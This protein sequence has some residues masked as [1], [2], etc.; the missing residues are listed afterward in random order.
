[1]KRFVPGQIRPP[2]LVGTWEIQQAKPHNSQKHHPL[3]PELVDQ[4]EVLAP[5]PNAGKS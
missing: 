4:Q 1:M 5:N 2:L 3:P